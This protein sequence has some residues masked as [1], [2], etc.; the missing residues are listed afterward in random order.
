M[1]IL[2]ANIHF[3][4]DG[5]VCDASPIILRRMNNLAQQNGLKKLYRLKDI[6]SFDW[7][8]E[9]CL[10]MGLAEEVAERVQMG[11]GDPDV[12][13]DVEPRF[14]SR[15][16][17]RLLHKLHGGKIN[18]VTSRRWETGEITRMWFARQLPFVDVRRLHVRYKDDKRSG[19]EIKLHAL[20]KSGAQRHYEDECATI[21]HLGSRAVIMD[22]PYNR[23][24]P[25]IRIMNWAHL[26][27]YEVQMHRRKI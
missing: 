11:W 2:P 24:L 16:S 4:I 10:R 12:V 20:D 19:K 21:T 5:V 13:S 23:H 17:L 15:L 27:A 18:F 14:M 25:G 8:K 3:D 6:N 1:E 22:R 9:E 26:L 7:V